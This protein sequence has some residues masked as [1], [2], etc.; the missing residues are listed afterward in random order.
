MSLLFVLLVLLSFVNWAAPIVILA[1][2]SPPLHMF[3]QLRGTYGLGKFSA[4]WRTVVL[5]G[6]AGVVLVLFMIFVLM[7]SM[8]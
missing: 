6:V 8:H 4:L 2:L 3:A 7:M 5:L 1:L